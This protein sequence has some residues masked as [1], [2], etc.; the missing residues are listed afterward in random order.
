[1]RQYSIVFVL[2]ALLLA[3]CT[4]QQSCLQQNFPP[5]LVSS[6]HSD[7][8][9]DITDWE[10]PAGWT[11]PTRVCLFVCR[12]G[13]V[14]GEVAKFCEQKITK[15]LA[16][17]GFAIDPNEQSQL[18]ICIVKAAEIRK[19][20]RGAK[21][22]IVAKFS[23]RLRSGQASTGEAEPAIV[24]IADGIEPRP[25]LSS[26]VWMPKSAYFRAA[27]YAIAKLMDQLDN[28]PKNPS[29]PR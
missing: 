4:G 2:P 23:P 9:I 18:T 12:E 13:G 16:A 27:Q 11:A 8:K 25:D 15:F 29:L 20:V 3:G 7:F 17:R 6:A 10:V 5:E 1:M 28:I 14:D 22:R 21:V 19:P 24:G 26:G